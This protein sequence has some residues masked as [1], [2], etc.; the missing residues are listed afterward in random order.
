ME[1]Y[2]N[3]PTHSIS[4]TDSAE[5]REALARIRDEVEVIIETGTHQGLGSTRILAEVFGGIPIHTIESNRENHLVATRNLAKFPS[6]QCHLGSSV[7]LED[8]RD[9]MACDEALQNHEAIDG[10]YIDRVDLAAEIARW[11][12]AEVG[13]SG[14]G[15]QN[16]LVS[17]IAKFAGRR[18]L[19]VLDSAGGI[20][21]LEFQIVMREM[22]GDRFFLLLDDTHHLKHFRSLAYL[23]RNT[24]Q[25]NILAEGIGWC[26]ADCSTGVWP[27]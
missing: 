25:F 9:F 17:L 2:A 5:L 14:V 22:V 21:W 4:M 20:G 1:P 11:Y 16:L 8:A 12:L 6:V 19:I 3:C 23:K 26:L 27:L 10:V 15:G 13:G 24:G 7:W 18:K